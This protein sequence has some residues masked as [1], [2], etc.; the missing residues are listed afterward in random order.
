MDDHAGHRTG[1][2]ER[3][4]FEHVGRDK[5]WVHYI[6]A[7]CQ[8]HMRT[9]AS[10]GAVGLIGVEAGL[11]KRVDCVGEG[12]S[13]DNG[14]AQDKRGTDGM[15]K[16]RERERWCIRGMTGGEE[17]SRRLAAQAGEKGREE[18]RTLA[19]AAF[20]LAARRPT[21]RVVHESAA[22]RSRTSRC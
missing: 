11:T 18:R 5:T 17:C 1:E 22:R 6:I 15:T 3:L 10:A 2:T 7:H 19:Y 14:A 20:R 8:M 12:P 16:A 21:A 4:A 9:Q 13:D